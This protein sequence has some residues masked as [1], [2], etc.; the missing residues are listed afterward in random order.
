MG[1]GAVC[2]TLNPRLFV[3]QLVYIAHHGEDRVIFVD[4]DLLPVLE[5]MAPRLP[6]LR[7]VV[8]RASYLLL[9]TQQIEKR[10]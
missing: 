5:S 2:H 9:F 8:V 10:Q 6:L 1:M 3:D 7:H 4:L